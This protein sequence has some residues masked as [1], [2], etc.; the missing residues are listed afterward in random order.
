MGGDVSCRRIKLPLLGSSGLT[1]L[2][3][4]LRH[5]LQF[6][7]DRATLE[8]SAV[9]DSKVTRSHLPWRHGVNFSSAFGPRR[10]LEA[11]A[12]FICTLRKM[13]RHGIH[14]WGSALRAR[15]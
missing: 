3:H 10:I 12:G 11:V 2:V 8:Q 9:V 7:V 6:G 1:I 15:Q 5:L 13:W 4:L 14:S